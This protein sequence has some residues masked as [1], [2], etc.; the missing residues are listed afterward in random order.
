MKCNICGKKNAIIHIQQV[1]GTEE[2][3]INICEKC[4]MERGFHFGSKEFDLSFNNLITN[5]NN[6]KKAIDAQE[7]SKICIE[8]GAIFEEFKKSG[9]AGCGA[10]YTEFNK[11]ISSYLKKTARSCQH[12][13]KH[14]SKIKILRRKQHEVFGLKKQLT[15]AVNCENYEEAAIL[16][17]KIRLVKK[18]I[19][20]NIFPKGLN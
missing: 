13:G 11:Y 3:S 5:F 4:A 7:N 2:I 17:D 19:N 15:K 8:C 10:C 16:K 1:S 9:I 14:P 20:N 6:I 18:Q 12:I